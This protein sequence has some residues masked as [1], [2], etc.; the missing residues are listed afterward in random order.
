MAEIIFTSYPCKHSQT[1]LLL[2][3]LFSFIGLFSRVVWT[4]NGTCEATHLLAVVLH[5]K[6]LYWDLLICSISWTWARIC[7]RL[8]SSGIDSASLCCLAGQYDRKGCCTGPPGWESIPGLLKRFTSTGSGLLSGLPNNLGTVKNLSSE[9][10]V[11][12]TSGTLSQLKIL[13][14]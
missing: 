9:Q 3:L 13:S 2:S 7:K 4:T 1:L 11:V 12:Q 14:D 10:K 6:G 8:R 5:L